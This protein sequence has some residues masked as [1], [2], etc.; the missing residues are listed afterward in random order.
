MSKFD[1]RNASSYVLEKKLL[2]KF[3]FNKN[4]LLRNTVDY[5]RLPKVPVYSIAKESVS[6]GNNLKHVRS[7]LI[8]CNKKARCK[9]YPMDI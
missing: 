6:M 4:P 2:L 5:R 7:I 8:P 9:L 3:S 1:Q